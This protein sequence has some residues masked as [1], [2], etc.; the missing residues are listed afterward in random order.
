M[1]KDPSQMHERL[2][3]DFFREMGVE[4]ARTAYALL[5]VNGE[6]QGLFVLVE[7]LDGRFTRRHFETEG[8]EGN[9]YKEVWP[10]HAEAQPY[11]DA[12]QT[13]ED[14]GDVTKMVAFSNALA[15]A[16]D[17]TFLGVLGAWTDL[18]WVY[19]YLAVDRGISH[20][21]GIT[22]WYCID[23]N[24]FNH[25]FYWYEETAANRVW[26]VPWDMDHALTDSPWETWFGVPTWRET[27]SCTPTTVF[28]NVGVR[29]ATCD[30]I[31]ERLGRLGYEGYAAAAQ[32]FLD[33]P[34]QEAPVLA[35]IDSLEA[36]IEDL[37]AADSHG[38]G[39]SAW[40][41]AV[42]TLRADIPH[43]RT[44]LTADAGL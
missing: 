40:R 32:R 21:D 15:G 37:V 42:D 34:F 16:T 14:V 44:V 12:L 1:N 19:A 8:G 35:K 17:E 28:A 5:N 30:P 2:A 6:P 3:Y 43:R 18:D 23:A 36:Q 39:L 13:N 31:I 22:A 10:E 41:T 25:N 38:P 26:L 27:A 9:L 4:T 24:C 33:G 29:A 7:Q 11:L 20:W